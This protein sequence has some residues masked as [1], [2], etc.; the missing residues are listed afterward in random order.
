MFVDEYWHHATTVSKDPE[1]FLPESALG[2]LGVACGRL[3]ILPVLGN[4]QHSVDGQTTGAQRE[5][6]FNRLADPKTIGSSEPPADVIGRALICVKGN[7]FEGRVIPFVIQRIRAKQ[8]AG[9]QFG[10]RIVAVN[11]DKR[12]HLS[13]GSRAGRDCA[14]HGNAGVCQRAGDT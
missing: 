10:V 7:E 5:R 1:S 12:G 14:L 4:Q 9:D 8:T 6:I 13:G 2:I 3:G 11:R